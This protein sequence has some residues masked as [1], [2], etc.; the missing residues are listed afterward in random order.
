MSYLHTPSAEIAEAI[1]RRK[2]L[3]HR[4]DTDDIKLADIEICFAVRQRFSDCLIQLDVALLD[5]LRGEFTQAL[6]ALSVDHDEAQ[7]FR[8]VI[9]QKLTLVSPVTT[10][11]SDDEVLEEV[12]Q[13]M[14]SLSA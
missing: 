13:R 10:R 3:D 1:Q 4:S 8:G 14:Q 12:I 5:V 6:D 11:F 2:L 7:H 9:Q